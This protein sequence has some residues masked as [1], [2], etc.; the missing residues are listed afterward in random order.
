MRNKLSHQA[1]NLISGY[2]TGHVTHAR[3]NINKDSQEIPN[4]ILLDFLQLYRPLDLFAYFYR[5]YFSEG[6]PQ[7]NALLLFDFYFFS[8]M[9]TDTDSF[10]L[11]DPLNRPIEI[12]R[13][14]ARR[15]FFAILMMPQFMEPFYGRHKLYGR[16]NPCG[17]EKIWN[18]FSK[19][20]AA[21]AT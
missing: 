8:T 11:I 19:R 7:N 4:K 9:G 15:A 21:G 17:C 6:L 10:F 3:C 18:K 13:R 16:I 14:P 20:F 1:K 5:L 2:K 12:N